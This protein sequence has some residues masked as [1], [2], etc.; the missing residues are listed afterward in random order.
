MFSYNAKDDGWVDME[1]FSN[2]SEKPANN[3][4]AVGFSEDEEMG[5][6]WVT[7]CVFPKEGKPTAH[8]SYNV[9]K[10][11]TPVSDPMDMKAEEEN[12]KLVHAHK[13]DDGL[14]CHIRQKSASGESKFV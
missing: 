7:Q 14:Y 1:I 13:G 8:F 5:S 10:S 9:G 4:I 12:L 6:D 3:Y 11:N 2:T